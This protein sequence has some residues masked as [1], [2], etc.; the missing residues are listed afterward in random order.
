MIWQNLDIWLSQ[1][2]RQLRLGHDLD[3]S[4]CYF[5]LQSTVSIISEITYKY[6]SSQQLTMVA[7]GVR[8]EVNITSSILNSCT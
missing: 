1:I 7:V 4:T 5:Y 3:V 8:S 2:A 6:M